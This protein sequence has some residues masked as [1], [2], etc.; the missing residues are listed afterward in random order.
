MDNRIMKL[1]RAIGIVDNL[2]VKAKVFAC[3]YCRFGEIF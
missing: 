3:A 2:V 1:P